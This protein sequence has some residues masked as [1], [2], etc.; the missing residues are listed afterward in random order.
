MAVRRKKTAAMPPEPGP[1]LFPVGLRQVQ[2]LERGAGE[3]LK[4]AFGVMG[5]QGFQAGFHL[6][7][8][9]QPMRLALETVFADQ[10]GQ[11]QISR[12]QRHAGFLVRF[13]AGADVR[14]FADVH[15]QFPAAGA[16]QAAVRLLRAFEQQHFVALAETIQQRG[17]FVGQ[18]HGNYFS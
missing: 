12:L 1:D 8:K 5:R 17:D 7:Q 14:R 16:P 18:N 9:H 13:A 2:T 4:T 6:E 11:V 10:A 3:K 15:L